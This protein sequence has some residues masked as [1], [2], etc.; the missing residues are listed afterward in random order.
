MSYLNCARRVPWHGRVINLRKKLSPVPRAKAYR[1]LALAHL[2]AI[3]S[4]EAQS[5]L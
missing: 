4:K 2:A 3:T 5:E 1:G